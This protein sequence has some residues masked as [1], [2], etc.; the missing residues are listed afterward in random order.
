[1]RKN[2]K[3]SKLE[4]GKQFIKN[5][6]KQEQIAKNAE[7]IELNKNPFI[8]LSIN[9]FDSETFENERENYNNKFDIFCFK[10]NNEDSDDISEDDLKDSSINQIPLTSFEELKDYVESDHKNKFNSQKKNKKRQEHFK[11]TAAD[12]KIKYKTELC[13]YYEINGFCKYGDNC[14]YAH[15]K[16]NLRAKITNTTAYRTKKC[17][18]FFQNG[19]CPYGNRCQFAHQVTSNIINNPYDRKMTYTKILETISK[20]ENIENIKGLRIKP[21]L[22]VFKNIVNNKKEIKN[23]LLEDI[24]NIYKE[25]IFERIDE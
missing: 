12:F 1:M 3:E 11:S 5:F 24:K 25:G 18:Q 2:K 19:Y 20:P 14:A 10:S 6:P 21:R 9:K 8:K 7:D 17:V 22:S 13:K 15:G 4:E 23:T 16:E